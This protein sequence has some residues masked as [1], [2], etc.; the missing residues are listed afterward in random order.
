M[1][2]NIQEILFKW[3]ED[4]S[5]YNAIIKQYDSLIK[6]G[7]KLSDS[8]DDSSSAAKRYAIES[9]KAFR[10]I[11]DIEANEKAVRSLRDEYIKTAAAAKDIKPGGGRGLSLGSADSL[12]TR[13]GRALTGLGARGA[14]DVTQGIGD[15]FQ[16]LD[17]GSQAAASAAASVGALNVSFA[18]LAVGGGALVAAFVLLAP[19]IAEIAETV[20]K[21]V[22]AIDA[23]VEGLKLYYETIHTLTSQEIKARIA[24]LEQQQKTESTILEA[25]KTQRQAATDAIMKATTLEDFVSAKAAEGKLN[26]EI[27]ELES[28]SALATAQLDAY[29]NA[30]VSTGVAAND[31]KALMEA[32]NSAILAGAAQSAQNERDIAAAYKLSSKQAQ[33]RVDSLAQENQ[34]LAVAKAELERSGSTTAE[35]QAQINNYN[36]ELNRNK[37]MIDLITNSIIKETIAREDEKQTIDDIV[38]A[39]KK[40]NEQSQQIEEQF[41]EQRLDLQERFAKQAEQI[42]ERNIEQLDQAYARL[43]DRQSQV[44][45]DS[46]RADEDEARKQAFDDLEMEIEF[47]REEQKELVQHQRRLRDIRRSS[48]ADERDALLDRNFLALFKLQERQKE[49]LA[50]EEEAKEE[51][52]QERL[53]NFEIER[54]DLAKQRAF[55]RN[56]RR[57][58]LQRQLDDAAMAYVKEVTLLHQARSKELELNSRAYMAELALLNNKESAKLTLLA[59]TYSEELRL[60]SLTSAARLELLEQERRAILIQASSFASSQGFGLGSAQVPTGQAA[61]RIIAGGRSYEF[62]EGGHARAGKPFKYNDRDP[63][64]REKFRGVM[65]PGG[66]GIAFPF[67]SGTVDPGKAGGFTLVQNITVQ[68]ANNPELTAKAIVRISREQAFDALKEVS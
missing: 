31:A 57:I 2:N 23:A 11:T 45:L 8:L 14:G 43:L 37:Q 1:A 50:Q 26:E 12:F 64:Q 61:Q 52:R 67:Q 56:E 3:V 53:K 6:R 55:E 66:S 41:G 36:N 18:A 60:A 46:A 20:N 16:L 59:S 28:N 21:G 68:G 25:L 10:T 54:A 40:F 7:N 19:K 9:K 48:A 24:D 44:L 30:L 5:S 63:F 42:I 32:A 13:G 29:K 35:V 58:A 62:A 22:V 4:R 34:A 47:N 15:F 17:V 65:L 33:E 49:E 51:A 38:K 27:K 39:T